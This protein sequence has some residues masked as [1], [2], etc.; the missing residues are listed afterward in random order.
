MTLALTAAALVCFASNSL[1]CRLALRDGS[2]DAATFT[3]VRILSGAGMLLLITG[4]GGRAATRSGSWETAALLALYAV[5]FAFAY[6]QLSTGTGA[7]IL[8]GSVQVTMFAAAAASRDR[9]GALQWAGAA[10]AFAGLVYLVLPGVTAPTARAAL[11]MTTA[12]VSWG[13]YSLRG[14]GAANPAA[15]TTSNFVRAVPFVALVM[16]LSWRSAHASASGLLVAVASGAVASGLG[17]VAWYAALRHISATQAGVVQLAG[18]VLA[19]GGGVLLLAEPLTPR[20]VAS[21][22]LVL[23]GIAL[24]SARKGR[25]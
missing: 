10:M 9:P 4:R 15:H 1:L 16:L 3:L 12:G 18:P 2:I 14:R 6:T 23:G 24:A 5:P 20:L 8:F 25:L 19:A 22:A 17:Y 11:L 7:L 13:F 21:A